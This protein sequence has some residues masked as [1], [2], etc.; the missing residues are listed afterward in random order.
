MI[1]DNNV[2]NINLS[3]ATRLVLSEF[4]NDGSIALNTRIK[5]I[6]RTYYNSERLKELIE[7]RDSFMDTKNSSEF[8]LDYLAEHIIKSKQKSNF[9]HNLVELEDR[10]NRESMNE[11]FFN[12]ITKLRDSWDFKNNPIAEYT[13]R[14]DLIYS[15]QSDT[16]K[17]NNYCTIRPAY[18]LFS[19]VDTCIMVNSAVNAESIFHFIKQFKEFYKIYFKTL[20]EEK[21]IT[22]DKAKNNILN[23]YE[24]FFPEHLKNHYKIIFP[25]FEEVATLSKDVVPKPF[26]GLAPMDFGF[27]ISLT[28]KI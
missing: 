8:V 28:C 26:L 21:S 1:T 9:N 12:E 25:K 11:S 2:K 20:C 13:K 5:A 18:N 22:I 19:E 24:T 16:F 27:V 3:E 15:C 4:T 6:I 23:Y 7:F 10:S 17:A 14:I